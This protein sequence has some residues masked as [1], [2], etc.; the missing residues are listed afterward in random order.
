[1]ERKGELRKGESA[2]DLINELK[3]GETFGMIVGNKYIVTDQAAAAKNLAEGKLTQGTVL[4]HEIK[5]AVDNLAFNDS[6]LINYSTN[7]ANWASEN[8]GPVT[9]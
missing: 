8:A 9:L 1:M 6:E 7:L 5:H 4:S 3:S 2:N